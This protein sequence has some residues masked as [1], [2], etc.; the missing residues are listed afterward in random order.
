M[1]RALAIATII[2]GFAL[3]NAAQADGLSAYSAYGT[4]KYQANF[5]HFDYVNADAPKGGEI[6]LTASGSFDSLNPLILSGTPAA[7]LFKLFDSLLKPAD[8]E[9][10][11]AYGLVAKS[12]ELAADMG[13]VTFALRPEARFNDGTALTASDVV[14]SFET[15]KRQGHP[16]F[17]LEYAPV[18]SAE[19]LDDHTVRFRFKSAGDRQ[20]PLVVGQMPILSRAWFAKRR[21]DRPTL[22]PL[23]TSGPY[24]VVAV[25]PGRSIA[26]ERVKDYWGRDLPV[27]RGMNNF[28]RIRFEYFRDVIGE[29]EAVKAGLC[30]FRFEKSAKNWATAY[31]GPALAT[32]ELV[33]QAMPVSVA[34]GMQGLAFNLRRDVFRDVRVRQ[35]LALAFDFEWSNQALFYAAYRRSDSYF[36]DSELAA[37]GLPSA[38]ELKLLE[39]LRDELPREVFTQVY[40]PPRTDRP[41]GLRQNLLAALELLRQAGWQVRDDRL[42]EVATGRPF[43]LEILLQDQGLERVMLPYARNLKRLGITAR[44]RLAD[45]TL[46]QHRVDHFDFDMAVIEYGRSTLPG[47]ELRD[48]FESASADTSGSGNIMGIKSLAIDSLIERLLLAHSMP[49][50]VASSRALDRALLWGHY[51]IP[52]WYSPSFQIVH[53]NNFGHPSVTTLYNFNLGTWW[54]ETPRKPTTPVLRKPQREVSASAARAG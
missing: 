45:A 14:W 46:Y 30:D 23:L 10:D 38:D 54:V 44:V 39:P 6:R 8:D 33:K 15:L 52:L 49:E 26:Y 4:P 3:A 17:R 36:A 42:V 2:V 48:Y 35:A 32:G 40:Q 50:L 31:A 21:F 43:E 11:S 27:N 28:D 34:H 53:K 37:R 20:L 13:S 9:V 5:P 41:N 7:G 25:D 24:R 12:M 51:L 1:T 18:A 16:Y 22:E 29:V 47:Q 19:A